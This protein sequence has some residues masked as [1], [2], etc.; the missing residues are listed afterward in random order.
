MRNKGAGRLMP[1]REKALTQ[2]FCVICMVLFAVLF[3]FSLLLSWVNEEFWNEFVYVKEDNVLLNLLGI[4]AGLIL[5]GLSGFLCEKLP[6]HKRM[7]VIAAAAGVVCTAVSVYWIIASKT[8]PQGDQANIVS[9]AVAYKNGDTS[10]LLKGGYVGI[11][12]QQLGLIT[13]MRVLF[14]FFGQGNY[15]AYQ[16]FSALMVFVI[17]FF[18]HKIIQ[19]I[20]GNNLKADIIYLLLM[21]CCIP[22]YGYTPFVYGEIPSTGMALL[23]A[24]ILLSVIDSFVWWK[25]PAL[26]AVCGAM[27]Q[28][29]QNTLIIAAAFIIVVLV[30]L[31]Q[32]A[33]KELFFTGLAVI[34]GI[35]LMQLGVTMI[36]KPFISEDTKSTPAVLFIAMGT[37]DTIEGEPGW[38][39]NYNEDLYSEAEYDYYTASGLG[40]EEVE[41]FIDKCVSDPGYAI[42]FFTLKM[43]IQ[44]NVPMY[45]CLVMNNSFYDEPYKFA[46]DIYFNGNDKEL[47]EFMNI[48]QLLVYGG[49]LCSLIIMRKRWTSVENWLL[50]ISV[51]G[52]FLFSMMWEAKP[53]YVFP[54]FILMIPY[55]AV[56]IA[57]LLD[58]YSRCNFFKQ[59]YT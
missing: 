49:V 56:G 48:Y 8:E 10:S 16:Y 29:R 6:I 35:A 13:F 18:G 11:H 52:G 20:S 54:Y 51:Y 47:E 32:R 40:W 45:Q 59:R 55:A 38:F 27:V 43:N 24:W 50:L 15:K 9:Y 22:M 4:A 28:L 23:A 57:E 37:H 36:Y 44:W 46:D 31:I 14:L 21:L 3:G 30:K 1:D 19:R 5:M 7:D 26:A 42:D 25:L 58:I 2:I 53:R 41:K 12:Q 39:D 17:I 33:R 34:A